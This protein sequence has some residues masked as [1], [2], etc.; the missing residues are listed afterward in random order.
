MGSRTAA[1]MAG[2]NP[3]TRATIKLVVNAANIA[4]HGITNTKSKQLRYRTR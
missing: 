4:P 3:E 2:Y 1:L